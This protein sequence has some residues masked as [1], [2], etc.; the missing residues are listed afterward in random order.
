M[1]AQYTAALKAAQ[2]LGVEELF[3]MPL[4]GGAFNNEP[5][6]IFTNLM[7]SLKKV[8][9]PN[10]EV[11]LLTWDRDS[12]NSGELNM[13]NEVKVAY[14]ESIKASPPIAQQAQ[15]AVADPDSELTAE[16]KASLA[17]SMTSDWSATEVV[18]PPENPKWGANIYLKV[19]DN[20][21]VTKLTLPNHDHEGRLRGIDSN[22]GLITQ[23]NGIL[24]LIM[25]QSYED[26][27]IDEWSATIQRAV[28]GDT[29]LDKGIHLM[30]DA[31]GFELD[32]KNFTAK[33]VAQPQPQPGPAY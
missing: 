17:A 21:R 18:V 33:K 27:S 20:L 31:D 4:G 10:C 7:K 11:K 14:E 24:K 2:D 9:L 30:K 29:T 12:A 23:E 16:A 1:E 32:R 28:N 13:Y 15:Q 26:G 3:I 6:N 19:D 25:N 5:Y 22:E 8:N